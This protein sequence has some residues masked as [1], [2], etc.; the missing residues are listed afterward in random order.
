MCNILALIIC[1]VI[2]AENKKIL[3]F[4]HHL[5]FESEPQICLNQNQKHLFINIFQ[6]QRVFRFGFDSKIKIKNKEIKFKCCGNREH[7]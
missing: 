1:S 5:D 2:F 7:I 6:T 4:E 3:N